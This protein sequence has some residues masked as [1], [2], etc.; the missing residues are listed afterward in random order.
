MQLFK[1]NKKEEHTITLIAEFSKHENAL[2]SIAELSDYVSQVSDSA[3]ILTDLQS[4][5]AGY[6]ITYTIKY[7]KKLFNSI[8]YTKYFAC[9][10][11]W[12][13]D[14]DACLSRYH[15]NFV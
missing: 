7:N 5:P 9:L 8:N 4:H 14:S 6:R 15:Y 3:V 13:C 10:S 12:L 11:Y 1:R 2:K